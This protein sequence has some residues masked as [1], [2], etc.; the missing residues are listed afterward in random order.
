MTV[1]EAIKLAELFLKLGTHILKECGRPAGSEIDLRGLRINESMK[2]HLEKAG[3]T[4]E[5]I[6]AA[7]KG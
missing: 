5:D 6:D 2:V 1:D 3:V 4:P 7:L